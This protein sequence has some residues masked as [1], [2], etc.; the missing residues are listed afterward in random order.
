MEVPA[1]GDDEAVRETI[2]YEV[3]GEGEP[4]VLSHGAGGNL[5][6]RARWRHG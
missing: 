1:G 2:Y 5:T 4:L 3:T 6:D